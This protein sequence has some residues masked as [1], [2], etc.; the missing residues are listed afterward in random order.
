MFEP[1]REVD[2]A[3]RAQGVDQDVQFGQR[4]DQVDLVWIDVRPRLG[5]VSTWVFA[6]HRGWTMAP[7]HA[8]EVEL[9]SDDG[10]CRRGP[11]VTRA[12]PWQRFARLRGV[13]LMGV[14]ANPGCRIA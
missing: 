11:L 9:R 14:R 7:P 12:L 3:D 4:D 2:V 13:F 1:I 6:W 10:R 8:A 5:I